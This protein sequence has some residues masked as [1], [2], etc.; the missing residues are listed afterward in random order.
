MPIS[1]PVPTHAQF[2]VDRLAQVKQIIAENPGIT[3]SVL[4]GLSLAGVAAGIEL[5]VRHIEATNTLEVRK[6]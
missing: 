3:V 2:K 5:R 4:D 6:E 1:V